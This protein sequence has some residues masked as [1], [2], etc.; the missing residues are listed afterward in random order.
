[1]SV[2]AVRLVVDFGKYCDVGFA[3]GSLSVRHAH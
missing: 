2:D 1:M 3:C